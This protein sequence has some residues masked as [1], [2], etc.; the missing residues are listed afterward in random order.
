MTCG[1]TH[2]WQIHLKLHNTLYYDKE[3]EE[4]GEEEGEEEVGQILLVDGY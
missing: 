2:E 3:E 4:E 1:I